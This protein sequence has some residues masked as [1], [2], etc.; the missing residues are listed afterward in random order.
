MIRDGKIIIE[1]ERKVEEIMIDEGG[2]EIIVPEIVG[3]EEE[4]AVLIL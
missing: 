3:T 2:I 1:G 4:K